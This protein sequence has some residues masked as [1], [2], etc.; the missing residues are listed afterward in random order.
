MSWLS[1]ERKGE[2]RGCSVLMD[3]YLFFLIDLSLPWK[4]FNSPSVPDDI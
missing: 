4:K 3:T 1:F 2:E